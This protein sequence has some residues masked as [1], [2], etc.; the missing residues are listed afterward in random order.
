M[1]ENK[2]VSLGNRVATPRVGNPQKEPSVST[3]DA[4]ARSIG[5]R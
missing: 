4:I 1:A 2:R 5:A 3:T